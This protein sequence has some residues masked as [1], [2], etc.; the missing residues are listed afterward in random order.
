MN[1]VPSRLVSFYNKE[2]KEALKSYTRVRKGKSKQSREEQ[3]KTSRNEKKQ[4][5]MRATIEKVMQ[6]LSKFEPGAALDV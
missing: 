3:K 4:K 1:L 5:L 6:K 2:R